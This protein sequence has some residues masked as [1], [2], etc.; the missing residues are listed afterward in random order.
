MIS[1]FS[2]S[3]ILLVLA[4]VVF[5]KGSYD[6]RFIGFICTFFFT[7]I[8]GSVFY[9]SQASLTRD[10]EI[11][12]GWVTETRYYED[13][14]EYIHRTCTKT[15]GS[16][17]N[18]RTVTYDCSYVQYHP[19][20]Y[21]IYGSNGEEIEIN[22][23]DY[24]NLKQKFG[25]SKFVDLY[26]HYHT[27]DGDMYVSRYMETK[28][29]FTPVFTQH[30][31]E[32]RVQ[33]NEGVFHYSEVDPEGLYTQSIYQGWNYYR[34]V[35]GQYGNSSNADLFLQRY[36]ARMGST[37]QLQIRIYIFNGDSSLGRKQ[38]SFLK[39]GNKNEFNLCLGL[40]NGKISW[41]YHFCFSPEGYTGNDEIGIEMREFVGKDADI[42]K[43]AQVL[44][45]KCNSKW[46][47]KDFDEFEY[48]E[49]PTPTWA[50]VVNYILFFVCCFV[51]VIFKDLK[52][53]ELSRNNRFGVNKWRSKA[54]YSL[55]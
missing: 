36:N 43:I 22:E 38:E 14:N 42:L 55:R 53:N 29:T 30:T 25:N 44:T 11:W 24:L 27:N 3:L 12:G 52:T 31:Y 33:A 21:M 6:G 46:R 51:S 20:V 54:S 15:V 17:K 4:I 5:V 34:S 40:K 2:L 8:A 28:E 45:E 9:V 13:W 7:L 35:Y 1:L 10:T 50:Y 26:R 37:K 47:R 32:N 49:V 23:S 18:Q 16:G 41:V 39:G 48:L 19:E